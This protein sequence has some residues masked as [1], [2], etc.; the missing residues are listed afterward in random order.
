MQSS[1][2]LTVLPAVT[3]FS[4][5]VQVALGPPL[6]YLIN[7]HFASL[8]RPVLAAAVSGTSSMSLERLNTRLEDFKCGKLQLL[9]C[10]TTLEQGIDVQSCE[11][12]VCYSK[13]Y[14]TKSHV[15]RAGRARKDK[16]EVC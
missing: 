10:T 16:A 4:L 3:T 11:F 14:T 2:T 1:L 8:G 13:F 12:V 5:C 15:Q 9:V 7:K 6:A